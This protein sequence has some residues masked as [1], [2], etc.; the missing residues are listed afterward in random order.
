MLGRSLTETFDMHG[1]LI[2]NSVVPTLP[3]QQHRIIQLCQNNW[4]TNTVMPEQL[5]NE[6]SYARTTG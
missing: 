1:H 4:I 2:S 5:D 3:E 6:H